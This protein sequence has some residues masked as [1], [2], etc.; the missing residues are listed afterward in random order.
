MPLLPKLLPH[1]GAFRVSHAKP[2]GLLLHGTRIFWLEPPFAACPRQE[3]IFS[4]K[5][6]HHF[7]LLQ[8]WM[9]TTSSAHCVSRHREYTT[10][11]TFSTS[12]S[13]F[14]LP[15]C[16]PMT[17]S[18]L[19]SLRHTCH[20]PS[21][22]PSCL[23]CPSVALPTH[24]LPRLP[25]SVASSARQLPSCALRHLWHPL[26]AFWCPRSTSTLCIFLYC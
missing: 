16:Q 3:S 22:P 15:P 4:R 23:V 14:E 26:L 6:H 18:H 24:Q 12:W 13:P 17:M 10:L 7:E 9:S 21:V 5:L 2:S 11:H 1:L 8:P 20:S 25:F 19:A